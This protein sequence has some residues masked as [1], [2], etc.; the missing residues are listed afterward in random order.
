MKRV[1][2]PTMVMGST[3]TRERSGS[4]S[5]TMLMT[6][7]TPITRVSMPIMMVMA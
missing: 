5:V 2:R 6:T 3:A 1:T 4:I 7:M